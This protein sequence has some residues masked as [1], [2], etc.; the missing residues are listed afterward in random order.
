MV[1]LGGATNRLP[2]P[3]LSTQHNTDDSL[4]LAPS[5]RGILDLTS[6]DCLD[7]TISTSLKHPQ[8]PFTTHVTAILHAKR[9]YPH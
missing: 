3:L 5:L 7:T 9:T 2:S 6:L 1:V 4:R 8:R